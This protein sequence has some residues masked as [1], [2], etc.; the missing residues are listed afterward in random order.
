MRRVVLT[1]AGTVTGLVA[2]LSL[3]MHPATSLSGTAPLARAAPAAGQ[4]AAAPAGSASAQATASAS[5]GAT[6]KAPAA[7]AA[8]SGSSAPA[9]PAKRVI[10]GQVISTPYGPMQVQVTV[11]GS[12]ITGIQ[13]LQQ[14]DMG[15]YSQQLDSSA[16]PQLTQE[17]LTAQSANISAVS[18]A[19]YTSSGY[20]QS[21]QS[22][23]DQVKA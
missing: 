20:A 9:A 15:S 8:K 1:L 3:K 7:S 22:A 19:S 11:L 21:L 2:L 18:G 12:K 16:V 4:P 23:L 17:A 13:V 6:A 14:T 5:A 10:T